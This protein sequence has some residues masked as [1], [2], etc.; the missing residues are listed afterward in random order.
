MKINIAILA[1]AGLPLCLMTTLA[2]AAPITE[3]HD[4]PLPNIVVILADDMGFG[5]VKSL[6]EH[7]TI[8]VSYTHLTLPTNR[9]V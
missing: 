9:E 2:T 5:D 7:S 4:D 3:T 6:N 8:P 1:L